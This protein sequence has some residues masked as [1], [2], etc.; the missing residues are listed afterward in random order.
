MAASIKGRAMASQGLKSAIARAASLS[1]I[2]KQA[3]KQ[4]KRTIGK[5]NNLVLLVTIGHQN[6]TTRNGNDAS[7][8]LTDVS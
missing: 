8:N 7:S 3:S 5:Y 2:G 1:T 6:K 4:T